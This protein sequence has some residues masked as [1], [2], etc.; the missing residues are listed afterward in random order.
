MNHLDCHV[1]LDPAS[2]ILALPLD[3]GSSISYDWNDELEF[4]YLAIKLISYDKLRSCIVEN[5]L[6]LFNLQ[7]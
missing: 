4:I 5:I 1:E 6:N 3:S 2:K 7:V